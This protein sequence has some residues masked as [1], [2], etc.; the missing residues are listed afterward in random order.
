MILTQNEIRNN[1]CGSDYNRGVNYFNLDKVKEFNIKDISKI[2][3]NNFYF[4]IVSKVSGNN[5]NIYTQNINISKKNDDITIDGKCSCPVGVNCKHIVAVCLEYSSKSK[6]LSKELEDSS[7]TIINSWIQELEDIK[8]HKIIENND[9]E[10]FFITYRLFDS[11]SKDQLSF[12]KTR[13]L[14]NDSINKGTL[15]NPYRFTHNY[16]N[17]YKDNK[18]EEISELSSSLYKEF[19]NH[20]I[21][22]NMK[23]SGK[24]GYMI[25]KALIDTN[26]LFFQSSKIP[27]SF[28]DEL[29]KLEIDISLINNSYNLELNIEK[30]N[31]KIIN[32]S[33]PFIIDINE[34]KIRPLNLDNNLYDMLNKAPHIPKDK[35]LTVC[36]KINSINKNIEIK[37]PPSINIE[38]IKQKPIPHITLNSKKYMEISFE[39]NNHITNYNPLENIEIIY[40]DD[41][42]VQIYKDTLYENKIID[43]IKDIEFSTK[44]IKD[45]LYFIFENKTKQEEILIWKDFI[46][47]KIEELKKDGFIIVDTDALD[48]KFYNNSN[49]I[50]N[51][52]KTNN[53]FNL[54]FDLEFDGRTQPI[55][56][57]VIGI[58]EEFNS[59]IDMPKM[60]NLEVETNHYIEIETK[61]IKPI[62]ET[63]FALLDKKQKDNSIKISNFDSHLLSSFNDNIIW[64]GDKE[65]LELSK[66]I[67]NFK[68]IS[69]VKPPKALTT[70]LR[71]YQQN[72]LNWLNFLYEFKFG[73]ILADDM[74]LGKTIQTLTHLSRLK[75][76]NRLKFPSLIIM[77]TSLIANWK[78]EISKFTP[79]LSVLS[80]Y[81][82]NR[83]EDFQNIDKYDII[84]TTYP[85]I[86]RDKDMFKNILFEYIILDEAQKIKN[87]KTK[88]TI[89]IKELNSNHKLALSGTPIENNLGELWSL[90]SFLMPGFLDTLTFFKKNFQTP[91]E[92]ENDIKK[93]ELLNKKIKPFMIRRTKEK[94]INE[95]PKKTEIVKYTQFESK[96]SSL[97][98]SIRVTME[99]KVR[100][101]IKDK[102]LSSSHITILDALLKLRQVCCDPSLLKIDGINKPKESAKLQ[103]F[104][105]LLS[106]LLQ[107]KRKILVFSQFTSMLNII[108]KE[109]IKQNIKYNKLTGSTTKREDVIESFRKGDSNIFLI[110]LK[111]GG[112]G[113][114]LIEADTVIHYDPWWNPAVENQATDR[115]YRI[116]QTKAVFVYKLIVKN[117][118][119]EKILELQQKKQNIQ[120]SLYQKDGQKDTVTFNNEELLELLK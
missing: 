111:A 37:I 48:V 54:S 71:K 80:L 46:T 40:Q 98:E 12:Y 29:F 42:I 76:N 56:P 51:N 103:L 18:D 59:F 79:N 7:N 77:P 34:N 23:F 30:S 32:T 53:W 116:G 20:N 11:Q 89:S 105:D 62:I 2:D 8:Q 24:L 97:Y 69:K 112:V 14:K 39:Y 96:Q 66:R 65:I 43:K 31:F 52:S 109:L 44:Y 119:E 5:R 91:I 113:L 17:E 26:R 19:F 1:I 74:G 33:P 61:V 55:A 110:S 72:G 100:D 115:I 101:T 108:E 67:K 47:N 3:D 35:I 4:T 92:K 87:P 93:Q 90:F 70:K 6:K 22:K 58:L 10:E 78:N 57:L 84:L 75:E 85:L 102:G 68:G 49:I 94:V 45:K 60:I 41:K 107:E 16:Y 106:E 21:Q 104:L 28:L 86:S 50:I 118:I 15:L 63:I 88:M 27:L 64:K 120:D 95:L 99:K 13:Y 82:S 114:N 38:K 73:G 9:E 36:N 83:Q 25:V 117:S 81:G